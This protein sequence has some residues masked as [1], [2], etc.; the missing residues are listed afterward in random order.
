[1]GQIGSA[2]W[3]R[4]S[5]LYFFMKIRNIIFKK[6]MKLM[7]HSVSKS[8][9][10]SKVSLFYSRCW[11]STYVLLLYVEYL[12][13]NTLD[14]CTAR[15]IRK[16]AAHLINTLKT[17]QVIKNRVSMLNGSWNNTILRKARKNTLPNE[18]IDK[19]LVES[20]LRT[21]IFIWWCGFLVYQNG[22]SVRYRNVFGG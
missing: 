11:T 21:N 1:M 8:I 20:Y 3:L 2:D 13:I 7:L 16:K 15:R 17:R 18:A 12:C 5:T 19:L 9:I 4:T 22:F 10:Q 14:H 6:D